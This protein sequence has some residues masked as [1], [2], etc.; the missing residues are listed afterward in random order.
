VARL[1]AV[2]VSLQLFMQLVLDFG[3]YMLVPSE[4]IAA[5]GLRAKVDLPMLIGRRGRVIGWVS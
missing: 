3:N 5:A 1:G 2:R 4:Q